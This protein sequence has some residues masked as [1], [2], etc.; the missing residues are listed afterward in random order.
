MIFEILYIY[1]FWFVIFVI[2][3]FICAHDANEHQ[4]VENEQNSFC[5]HIYL[6]LARKKFFFVKN[7]QLT[8][9]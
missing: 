6:N 4:N 5:F 1:T 2:L 3:S 9:P 7:K 8:N